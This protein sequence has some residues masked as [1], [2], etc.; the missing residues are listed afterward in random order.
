M[1]FINAG[2]RLVIARSRDAATTFVL[3]LLRQN[4]MER[5]YTMRL[6]MGSAIYCS[7][8]WGT[9]GQRVQFIQ[10]R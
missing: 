3:P 8:A 7:D 9:L 5:G 1:F 6:H 4:A 10:T 2:K